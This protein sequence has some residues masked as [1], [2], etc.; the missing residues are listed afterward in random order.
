M[1]MDNQTDMMKQIVTFRNFVN[2]PK[3]GSGAGN[4]RI[5]TQKASQECVKNVGGDEKEGS[6]PT[7]MFITLQQQTMS[8]TL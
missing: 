5:I 2:V 7:A 1:S 8:A 3:N 4:S 6:K